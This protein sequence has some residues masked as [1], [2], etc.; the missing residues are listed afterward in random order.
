MSFGLGIGRNVGRGSSPVSSSSTISLQSSMH[1]SQIYTPGPATSLRSWAWGFAK[2]EHRIFSR[3]SVRA[4]GLSFLLHGVCARVDHFVDQAVLFG[5]RRIHPKVA[6]GVAL[7]PFH[8][9][10]G[11]FCQNI[12]HEKAHFEKFAGLNVYVRRGALGPAPRLVDH[13]A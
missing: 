9:L 8:R 13:D 4:N 7:D 2:K 6:V 5:L 12:I 11:M 3:S 10:A 1:S